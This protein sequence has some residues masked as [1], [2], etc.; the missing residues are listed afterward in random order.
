[1]VTQGKV[2]LAG[3]TGD[4]AVLKAMKSNEDDTNQ[5][6]ERAASN[7]VVPAR[8]RDVLRACLADERRHRSYIEEELEEG[9]PP[10]PMPGGPSL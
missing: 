9:E 4:R 1:V 6:Y 10:L 2:L 8:L 7:D 3:L 5:A